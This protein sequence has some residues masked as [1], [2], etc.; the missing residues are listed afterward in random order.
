ME[1]KE[2]TSS[3]GRGNVD[4]NHEPQR[5]HFRVD[6]FSREPGSRRKDVSIKKTRL[7]TPICKATVAFRINQK[8]RK[9]RGLY[10]FVPESDLDNSDEC[11]LNNLAIS[12]P[13]LTI[14]AVA[15]SMPA[16]PAK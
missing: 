8:A 5:T 11:G 2:F 6:L 4:S 14:C 9:P 13:R 15:G 12:F 16:R 7:A 10:L 1:L 3:E